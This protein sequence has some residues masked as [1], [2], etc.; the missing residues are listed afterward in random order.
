MEQKSYNFPEGEVLLF[1]K[2]YGWT[3]FDLVNKVRCQLKYFLKI[4]KI[5]IGHA[6]TLDPLATGLLILCTGKYTKQIEQ[7]QALEKEYTGTLYLGS[8]TPSS[9]METAVDRMYDIS[10]IT[11]EMIKEKALHFVGEQMQEPPLFSAKKIDGERAYEYARRGEVRLLDKKSIII[12]EFEITG[13][14]L[15]EVTFR[16]VCSKGTYIRSLARDFGESLGA[17]AYLR[18]LC[19]TRIGGF[20]LDGAM[21]LEEFGV[22]LSSELGKRV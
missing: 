11:E 10:H 22:N 14:S 13:I 16:V 8:T 15:P 12:S 17:G 6:G 9:D 1:N 5:K 21:E 19:R 4:K 3:S 18:A 2:P 7:F 20:K